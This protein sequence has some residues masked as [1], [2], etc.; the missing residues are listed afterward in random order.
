M[1]ILI[2]L[3][4]ATFMTSE[5]HA[6]QTN[7]QLIQ[8]NG[9]SVHKLNNLPSIYGMFQFLNRIKGAFENRRNATYPNRHICVWKICSKPLKNKGRNHDFKIA[10]LL[11]RLLFF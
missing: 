9:I 2:I 5:L 6:T 10:D 8:D 4:F 11:G 3:L 1:K 7:S